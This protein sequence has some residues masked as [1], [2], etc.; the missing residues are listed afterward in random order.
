[1]VVPLTLFRD[2]SA[3]DI[4]FDKASQRLKYRQ[5]RDAFVNGLGAAE[6][7]LA[8]S[9]IPSPLLT[10]LKPDM[11][12]AGYIAKD[13]EADPR[14]IVNEAHSLGCRIALPYVTGKAAPMQF[15]EWVP[16]DEL[17][18]GPFGLQQP[19]ET[20]TRCSPDI[21]LVP[22]IAFDGRLMRLGQGAGHYDRALSILD[23][24]IAVGLAWSMQMAPAL[25]TDPW[26][27]PMDAILTEQS[28]ITL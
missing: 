10:L 3:V 19:A 12:V 5:L 15:L 21:V 28:W 24:A 8:F 4:E 16:G 22:L 17:I 26:D 7:S 1:M 18:S 27:V 20:S 25:I 14:S 6:K 2:N 11:I 9:R 23:G 13:G